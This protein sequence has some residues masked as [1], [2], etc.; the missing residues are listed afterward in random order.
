MKISREIEI[1]LHNGNIA[2]AQG[3]AKNRLRNLLYIEPTAG[4]STLLML[5][6]V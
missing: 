4:T 5:K 1:L 3:Y 6:I 2:T